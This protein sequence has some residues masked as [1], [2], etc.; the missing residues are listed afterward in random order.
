MADASTA[1]PIIEA[2]CRMSP[3]ENR[4]IVPKPQAADAQARRIKRHVIRPPRLYEYFDAIVRHGSIRRAAEALGI[5]SSALN[6][7]LL[8]LEADVG[9]RLFE[10]LQRGVRLTAPGECSPVT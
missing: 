3:K 6:R 1:S 10:R 9:A 8:D 7:R 5:A 2:V 4:L